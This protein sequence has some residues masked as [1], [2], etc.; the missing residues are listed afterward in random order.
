[1]EIRLR[2]LEARG[3]EPGMLYFA[4]GN[5]DQELNEVIAQ[6]LATGDLGP[7]DP[8]VCVLCEDGG[9]PASDWRVYRKLPEDEKDIL[10]ARIEALV[11]DGN[12][13]DPAETRCRD[14]TD[15]QLLTIA[16]R[17]NAR[18][19]FRTAKDHSGLLPN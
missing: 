13:I 4:W 11:R 6:A 3:R 17:R 14:M 10:F 7:K 1:M 18:T 19:A 12:T 15:E 2:K 8:N 5:T 16:L 9:V